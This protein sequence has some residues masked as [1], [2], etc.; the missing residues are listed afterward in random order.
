META[1][2]ETLWYFFRR[3]DKIA[4]KTLFKKYYPLLYAYGMKICS[5]VDLTEDNLQNLFI[6]L[7]ENAKNLEDIKNLKAYLFVSFKRRL[8]KQVKKQNLT[9]GITD[10]DIIQQNLFFSPQEIALKQDIQFLCSKTLHVLLN[11][12]SPR[13]K[14]VVYL[15]YYSGLNTIEISEVMDITS[16]SVLNTLQKA[17]KRLRKSSENQIISNILKKY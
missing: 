7:F 11:E 15:K 8:L 3:G 12:L 13:E 16:Q 10:A 1:T 9:T 17:M 14:E 4:F 2:D 6:Y 5:D